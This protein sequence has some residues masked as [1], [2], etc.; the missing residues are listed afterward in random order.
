MG[1]FTGKLLDGSMPNDLRVRAVDHYNAPEATVYVILLSTRAGEFD[2]NLGTADTVII[3]D[4][5]WNPQNGLQAETRAH[6]IGQ[7]KDVKYLG[8]LAAKLPK[9]ISLNW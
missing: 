4:S 2:V 1:R 3:F 9:K 5:D 6:R 8:C 7:A